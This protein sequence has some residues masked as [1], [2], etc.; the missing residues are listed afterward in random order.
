MSKNSDNKNAV[1]LRNTGPGAVR[2]VIGLESNTTTVQFDTLS[3]NEMKKLL[4]D[5]GIKYEINS[6]G[7]KRP[8]SVASLVAP[9]QKTIDLLAQDPSLLANP[10][11]LND[12]LTSEFVN[13]K[14]ASFSSL[15][16][17]EPNRGRRTG[18]R[19]SSSKR[20]R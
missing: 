19:D 17:P 20:T 5:S 2:M 7:G 15:H 3:S 16:P 14:L 13:A 11:N 9:L 6:F 12:S 10:A 4:D 1:F 8:N 18:A